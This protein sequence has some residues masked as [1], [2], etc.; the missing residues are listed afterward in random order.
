MFAVRSLCI[1]FVAFL[2]YIIYAANTQSGGLFLNY[3]YVLPYGDKVGHLVLMGT[4][5]LLANLSLSCRTIQFSGR[6]RIMLGTLIV[7]TVVCIEEL[8]QAFIASRS[9]DPGD[10][11]ADAI[12]IALGAALARWLWQMHRARII[13]SRGA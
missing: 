1:A 6:I 2:A 3:V 4:L 12:G 8:S 10:L 13:R 11:L 7:A 5:S 9:C